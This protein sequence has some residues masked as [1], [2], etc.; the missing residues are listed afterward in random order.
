MSFCVWQMA[1]GLPVVPLEQCMRT[2]SLRGTHRSPVG[3]W[4]RR[5]CLV[6]K[7]MRRMSSSDVML[8]GHGGLEARQLGVFDL[9][10]APQFRCIENFHVKTLLLLVHLELQ[11]PGG[12][13]PVRPSPEQAKTACQHHIA[14]RG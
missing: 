4:S 14:I 6:V 10:P 3:Y 5:S 1:T 13:A 8:S 9:V 7:G 12:V 2:I 11:T